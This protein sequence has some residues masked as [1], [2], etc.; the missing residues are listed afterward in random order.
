MKVVT[1]DKLF[2]RCVV[3]KSGDGC[4]EIKCKLGLWGVTGPS[5]K[6]V[7]DEARHYWIQY[8][9]DGEYKNIK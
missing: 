8:Y 7:E 4:Y 9:Q 6:S 5:R 2:D 3:R 1:L